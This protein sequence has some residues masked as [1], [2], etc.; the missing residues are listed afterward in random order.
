M[1]EQLFDPQVVVF[2][3]LTALV[4]LITLVVL[5]IVSRRVRILM[6]EMESLRREIALVDESLQTVNA[7]LQ[8]LGKGGRDVTES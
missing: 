2:G 6:S 1:L 4:I 8:A 5:A 7:S 3:G